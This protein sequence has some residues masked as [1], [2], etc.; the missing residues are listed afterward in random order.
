V[1]ELVRERA[2]DQ[3]L[4]GARA[5]SRVSP[6]RRR[7]HLPHSAS[8]PPP[9]RVD[10][11]RRSAWGTSLHPAPHRKQAWPTVQAAEGQ[12]PGCAAATHLRHRRGRSGASGI[13]DASG[14]LSERATFADFTQ[15][16]R[17][18]ER[19]SSRAPEERTPDVFRNDDKRTPGAGR[20]R[21]CP[22]SRCGTSSSSRTVVPLS[23]R[24]KSIA[25]LEEAMSHDKGHPLAAQKKAKTNEPAPDDIFGKDGTLGTIL[26]SLRPPRRTV[27]CW[28]GKRR[29]PRP[30]L[31]VAEKS[32]CR[33]GGVEEIASQRSRWRLWSAPCTPLESVRQA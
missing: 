19:G 5:S 7:G 28:E 33:G 26:R 17:T 2:Q 3:R 12:V 18:L 21:R 9:P 32:S 14:P 22:S 10:L 15:E 20:S 31:H 8:Q 29:G 11:R 6:K 13:P 24:E 1:L 23:W 27:K 30:P 25:A 16:K 4:R